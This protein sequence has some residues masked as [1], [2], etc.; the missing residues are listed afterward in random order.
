LAADLV[1]GV[2]AVD[3]EAAEVAGVV[4]WVVP[5]FRVGGVAERE[6]RDRLGVVGGDVDLAA[7]DQ[8]CDGFGWERANPLVGD[9]TV[10]EPV[11]GLAQE[12]DD[13]VEVVGRGS[14]HVKCDAPGG[15][16]H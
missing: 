12:G 4:G 13:S 10:D 16:G 14:V 3:G 8:R 6:D 11:L 9:P 15:R 7:V 5:E 1:A 2:V